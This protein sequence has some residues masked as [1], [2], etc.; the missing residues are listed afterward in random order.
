MAIRSFLSNK[1]SFSILI[2]LALLVLDVTLHRGITRVM[3]PSDFTN[4]RQPLHIN[5]CNN[6]LHSGNKNWV[7]A[8]NNVTRLNELPHDVSGIE[9]D[10]YYDTFANTFYA[11]HDSANISQVTIETLLAQKKKILPEASVWFDFKNLKAFNQQQALNKLNQL[12]DSFSLS[13]KCIVESSNAQA[14]EPFCRAGYFTSYYV[15]FYNPYQ[16]D[17]KQTIQFID[18]IKSQISAFPSSAL[19]GYYFQYP[20]LKKFF[21]NYPLLIWADHSN[22]SVVGFVFNKQVQHDSSIRVFL[23]PVH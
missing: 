14:L 10:V 11:Y 16:G 17:E 21:P 9:I 3:I 7:K 8:I 5:A 19:S 4:K 15:P 2:L 20:L 18:S 1:Y 13:E 23:T 22:I 6:P 12:R